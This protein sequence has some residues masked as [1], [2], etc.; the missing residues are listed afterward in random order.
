MNLKDLYAK[1]AAFVQRFLPFGNAPPLVAVLVLFVFLFLLPFLFGQCT[2]KGAEFEFSGGSTVVRGPAS[3]MGLKVIVPDVITKNADLGCGLMLI[4]ASTYN[5]APQLTQAAVH[6]QI[7]SHLDRF[8]FGLGAG[9]LQHDDAY[10]GG[11]V[12]FSLMLEVR[13]WEQLYV[14]YQHFSNSGSAAPNLGRDLALLSW[15]FR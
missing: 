13:T 11:K 15:R 6:C 4:G 12:N 14:Q 9:V 5:G 10:N 2:A 1:Y 8:N 7:I 3:A